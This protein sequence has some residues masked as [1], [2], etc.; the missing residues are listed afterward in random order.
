MN[1]NLLSEYITYLDVTKGYSDKT[2]E[3]YRHYLERFFNYAD[4]TDPEGVTE[5]H[6]NDF[7]QYLKGDCDLKPVTINYHLTALRTF[8][9][10][11]MKRGLDVIAADKIELA[12][13]HDS[14]IN[15]LKPR[16]VRELLSQPDTE[17]LKGL[18]D[19]AILETLY[20]T[21]LRR[22]E[23][24]SLDR[25]DVEDGNELSVNGKGRKMR[26]VFLS[27]SAREAVDAYIERRDD[28]DPAL[29]VRVGSAQKE[30]RRL[31]ARSVGD[32]VR[33][34]ARDA[35]ITTQ[36]T[37]HVIR[38]TFATRLLE[39]G[40]DIRTVQELLGHADISTTQRY[41]HVTDEHLKSSY[42]KYHG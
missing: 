36:V 19:R 15:V 2:L 25:A 33:T 3:N 21:G 7:R 22:A 6:I 14:K 31:S 39:N 27:G 1:S 11:C 8:C 41:M 12:Q 17:S 18:R 28:D 34:H 20:S 26:L 16:A 32:I 37:P 35:G 24:V 10:W 30:S 23:L 13:T 38:H 29:F 9:R 5:N 42:N 4:I 40:A